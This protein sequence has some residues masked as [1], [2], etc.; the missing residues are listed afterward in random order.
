M[1]EP[2]IIF[3]DGICG[4]CNRTVDFVLREDRE[5]K[6]LSSPLQGE[7]FKRL[8]RSHPEALNADSIFVLRRGQDKEILL[9]RS[10]AFLH[11]LENL[12]RYRWLALIG[13]R[14]PK[15]TRDSLYRLIAATRYR[16]WG[17]LDSCRIPSPAEKAKFLP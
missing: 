13:K 7:T 3:F 2:D 14:F 4:L 15:P 11:I 12:P 1:G 6:F 9:Q 5:E 8:T 16:I 10:D 17:K